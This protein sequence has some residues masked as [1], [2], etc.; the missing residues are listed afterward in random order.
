MLG[1]VVV[2]LRCTLKG[3]SI[4]TGLVI[5]YASITNHNIIFVALKITDNIKL[6]WTE[7]PVNLYKPS[8]KNDWK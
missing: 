6:F 5:S 2:F 8:V 4:I 7:R 3:Y 1:V